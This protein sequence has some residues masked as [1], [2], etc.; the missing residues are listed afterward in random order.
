MHGTGLNHTLT[1]R[2]TLLSCQE[3][4]LRKRSTG[5]E[6]SHKSMG[7]QSLLG[8]ANN[9][10]VYMLMGH[11]VVD[12]CYAVAHKRIYTDFLEGSAG[13]LADLFAEHCDQS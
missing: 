6:C 9:T 2:Q 1:Y 13:E 5:K 4:H 12:F 7:Y 11:L 10:S 3:T 8:L